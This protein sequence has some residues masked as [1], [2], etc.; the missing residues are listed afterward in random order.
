M[1]PKAIL[2]VRPKDNAGRLAFGIAAYGRAFHSRHPDR[3]AAETHQ[4]CRALLEEPAIA[5]A[6]S[7]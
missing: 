4:S 6:S 1:D 2:G 3:R 7:Y 5:G